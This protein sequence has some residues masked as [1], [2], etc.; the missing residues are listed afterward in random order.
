M[1]ALTKPAKRA[2][3]AHLANLGRARDGVGEGA[4][5]T[6]GADALREE[7]NLRRVRGLLADRTFKVVVNPAAS[8]AEAPWPSARRLEF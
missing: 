7:E 1:R 3:I 5:V 8:T 6:G 2:R 4:D